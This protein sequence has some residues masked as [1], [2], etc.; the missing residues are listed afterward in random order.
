MHMCRWGLKK[1][2][3]V[4][5]GFIPLFTFV[6]LLSACTER[7]LQMAFLNSTTKGHKGEF[8]IGNTENGGELA[9]EG[10][11]SVSVDITCD[12]AIDEIEVEN[13]QTGQWRNV[14]ELASGTE[15]NCASAGEAKLELP[16]EHIAPY[17]APSKPGDIGQDFKIRWYVKNLEGE[18]H[19]FYRTLTVKFK[20]PEVS[21]TEAGDINLSHSGGGQYKISGTCGV[22]DGVVT[23]SGPFAGA[24]IPVNC[25]SNKGFSV[26]TSY[27][28]PALVAGTDVRVTHSKSGAYRTYSEIKKTVKVDVVPPTVELLAPAAGTVF[29]ASDFAG[30]DTVTVS[31]TCSE[32]QQMVRIK[33]NGLGIVEVFCSADN[34]FQGEVL[35]ASEGDTA[36]QVEHKDAAGNVIDSN[37]TIITKDTVGPGSFTIS[38]IRSLSGADTVIDN[39][40]TEGGPMIYYSA[41]ADAVEYEIIVKSDDGVTT[42]CP[43]RKE[44]ASGATNFSSC[45]LAQNTS[46]R[47]YAQAKD[48]HGNMTSASNTGFKF[49]TAF[50][51]PKIIKVYAQ[52]PNGA[53]GLGN[54]ITIWV[55][56]DR[57]ITKTG[58]PSLALN[59]GR[60]VNQTSVSGSNKALGFSLSVQ[61]GD[62]VA[63]LAMTGSTLGNCTG[64]IVDKYNSVV[65]ADLTLPAETGSNPSALKAS[66]VKVDALPPNPPHSLTTTATTYLNRTAAIN[67]TVPADPDLL[68][69][70]A[71]IVNTANS[72]E[73]MPWGLINQGFFFNATM[74]SGGTY[75][76]QLRARDPMNN[77]STVAETTFT[78]FSCPS[79][80]VYIHNPEFTDVTPFCVGQ[81]EAKMVSGVPRFIAANIP[82]PMS[83]MSATG[84]CTGKGAGYDL[85]SNKEWNVIAD[86]IARQG[87]NWTTGTMGSGLLHRGDSQSSSPTAANVGDSC[88]PN[89]GTLCTSNALRRMHY[90]PYDQAIWDFAGNAAEVIKDSDSV[91]Y[92]DANWLYAATQ[93]AY[94]LDTKYGTTLTCTGISSPDYCGFGK[95][96]FATVG[97]NTIWRGG[98]AYD[99][100]SAGIFAAKRATDVTA[101]LTNGG[102]R[103]VY[104]P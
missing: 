74:N 77:V 54:T 61:N 45:V 42:A 7:D 67:F 26:I 49:T 15:F 70:E 36:L 23:I 75:K 28:G 59:V 80:F 81:F 50:P 18:T 88:A 103:C 41:A 82:S 19:V 89:T 104:H 39:Q 92:A 31:G 100:N 72:A 6:L 78:A 40:L 53:Y 56:F 91:T 46:Y 85:I 4:L 20:A 87:A 76:Y 90:L 29:V 97:V 73:V 21:I 14:T 11:D 64:C 3:S 93:T 43:L 66:N 94:Q 98:A 22:T 30:K 101:T 52:T 58:T 16:L 96:D 62:Y 2:L 12:K 68:T 8:V 86:L 47:I 24:P 69:I 38:G 57:E 5:G 35:V 27:S 63:I 99:G 33:T 25:D 34:K 60:S 37:E 83:M 13:P 95:I 10:G 48:A 1:L 84:A 102:F 51:V 65:V 44:S 9:S 71:R 79:E 17:Q 55:E 32:P